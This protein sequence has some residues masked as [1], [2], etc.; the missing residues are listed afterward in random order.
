[1]SRVKPDPARGMRDILPAEARLRDEVAS[2]ALSTYRAYG[3]ERIETP[4]MERI[5]V[6]SSGQGGENEK[7]I[8]QV[9]KRGERLESALASGDAGELV[10]LGLRYDLT[11]PLARFYAANVGQ[12]PSPF[13]ALQMGPVWRA[14]RP[15]KGRFRQ[16]TQCDIDVVGADATAEVE[17]VVATMEALSKLEVGPFT[18]LVN[19]RAFLTEVLDAAG[20]P[21]DAR[22][23]ALITLDKADKIG[24]DRVEAELREQGLADAAASRAVSLLNTVGP[25]EGELADLVHAASALAPEGAT[26]EFAPT[27]VRGMGYYTGPIFEA[28][29]AG[30]GSSI[31]GGGRYDGLVERF[32]GR[33]VPACGFSLGF[34]R[35]VDLLRERR[36][37]APPPRVAILTDRESQV[38][39]MGQAAERRAGGEVVSVFGR[40][41]KV[42]KQAGALAGAGYTTVLIAEG[43]SLRPFEFQPA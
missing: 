14:E 36:D 26:V 18:V 37:P 7:L 13:K 27:L 43:E 31:A 17:L 6:L 4:A 33:A 1:M 24:W 23:G 8:F 34:E 3:Y 32:G 35:I 42:G 15:Q 12:L 41:K 16:F 40:A 39:A 21:G 2:V 20:V 5:E 9:L 29:A 10:D 30:Y 22:G 25:P 38:W 28:K 11:L 19:D